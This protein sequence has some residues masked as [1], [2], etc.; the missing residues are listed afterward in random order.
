MC[1]IEDRERRRF[2]YSA[3]AAVGT[4]G[5]VISAWPIIDSMNPGADLPKLYEME[6]DLTVIHDGGSKTVVWRNEP[7]FI[8]HRTQTEIEAA[9]RGD[10]SDLRDP[11]TDSDRVHS[12]EWLA[13]VGVCT[14]LGCV[15][16]GQEVVEHRGDYG[17]WF[18]VCCASHFDTSGRVRAGAAPKNL[19]VPM[20]DILNGTTMAFR[21]RPTPPIV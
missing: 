16:H 3:T 1:E 2:L 5:A 17:G 13:V 7:I 21:T 11:E 6:V 18:C 8:R 10:I 15:L 4:C 19:R 20:Y 9:R 14:R 12:P